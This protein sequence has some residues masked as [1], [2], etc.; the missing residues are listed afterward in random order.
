MSLRQKVAAAI[1]E[2]PNMLGHVIKRFVDLPEKQQESWLADA[3]RALACLPDVGA[4]AEAL[5]EAVRLYGKPGGPWNV[6]TEPGNWL[7]L[8]RSALLA[9]GEPAH[10]PSPECWC[11]PIVDSEEPSLF[12]HRSLDG[13]E[14]YETGVRKVA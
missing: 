13:R 1:Y 3:D 11:D 12:I 9:A 14:D 10:V 5:S 7:T 2:Q 8:A 6:P 4:M